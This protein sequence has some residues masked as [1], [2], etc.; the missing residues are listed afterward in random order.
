MQPPAKRMRAFTMSSCPPKTLRPIASTL[1]TVRAHQG[2]HQIEIVNHQIEH[3]PNVGR[4]ARE[5]PVPFA[6]DQL[7]PERLG[8]DR[9]EGGIEALDVADLNDAVSAPGGLDDGIRLVERRRK[10]LFDEHMDAVLEKRR[11]HRVMLHGR[12]DD[13]GGID[14]IE[15]RAKVRE[16]A[17]LMARGD[18][19]GLGGIG[20]GD[21]DQFHVAERAQDP[22]V[23]LAE[24]AH[25]DHRHPQFV[26][27]HWAFCNSGGEAKGQLRW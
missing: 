22:C 17:G 21:S 14:L 12:H 8:R 1:S 25:A 23:S 10:R 7:G 5:R 15:Q 3:R 27:S 11:R 13:A 9:F 26:V 18:G 24:V 16:C 20:V 19:L 6:L 2:E 4:S